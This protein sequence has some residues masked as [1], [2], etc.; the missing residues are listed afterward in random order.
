[1]ICS[2]TSR[3]SVS[4]IIPFFFYVQP[5]PSSLRPP[6]TFTMLSFS[7]LIASASP[8]SEE[9]PA[10]WDN[11]KNKT[12]APQ[13]QRETLV[14]RWPPVSH[15]PT[16]VH[17]WRHTHLS[18]VPKRHPYTQTPKLVSHL[19]QVQW[20]LFMKP[21]ITSFSQRT[22]GSIQPVTASILSWEN[23]KSL[24]STSRQPLN[25]SASLVQLEIVTVTSLFIHYLIN[26]EPFLWNYVMIAERIPGLSVIWNH[27]VFWHQIP[28]SSSLNPS[29]YLCDILRN[30]L[31]EFLRYSVQKDKIIFLQGQHQHL[32]FSPF[33]LH[34]PTKN[35]T[36]NQRTICLQLWLLKHMQIYYY[37]TCT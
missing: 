34:T 28:S 19:T 33:D 37:I 5:H 4:I 10:Y 26:Y 27:C 30:S 7:D 22:W 31:N 21:K 24:H 32:D 6:T 8:L 2:N 1:M 23:T 9:D 29:G 20:R 14:H 16:P 15:W 11:F 25:C 13:R 17:T 36:G 18:E 12:E 3:Q 35:R